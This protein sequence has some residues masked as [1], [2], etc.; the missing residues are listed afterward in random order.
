MTTTPPE[1]SRAARTIDLVVGIILALLTG[2]IGLV[3][4]GY[5]TQLGQLSTLCDGVDPDGTRCSPG[6]LGAMGV[7]G[8]AIVVLGWFL[9][10][11]FLVVRAL[12]RRWVFFLPI[13]SLVVMVAGYFLVTAVLGG[14]YLPAA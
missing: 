8:T 14:A 7:L 11:G 1:R 5:M 2:L 13:V 4:L 6:F 12:Q 3:M 9:P 10:T